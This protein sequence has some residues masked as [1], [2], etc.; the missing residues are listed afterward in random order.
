MLESVMFMKSVSDSLYL[1]QPVLFLFGARTEL[2]L[3]F[4]CAILNSHGKC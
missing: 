4:D 2:N 3:D 1:S